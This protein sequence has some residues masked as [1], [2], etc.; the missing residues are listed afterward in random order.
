MADQVLH[1]R[2]RSVRASRSA[3]PMARAIKIKISG[4][5]VS[6]E[7]IFSFPLTGEFRCVKD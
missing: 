5:R 7:A 1:M 3:L 2:S 4:G 6:N